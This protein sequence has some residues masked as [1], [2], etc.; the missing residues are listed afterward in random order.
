MRCA[1]FSDTHSNWEALSTFLDYCHKNH[2]DRYWMLGDVV[3]YGADPQIVQKKV[4]EISDV[5]IRGNHDQAMVD[6]ELLAWFNDEAKEAILW[7][8]G[9]FDSKTKEKLAS[10]PYSYVEGGVTLVHASPLNFDQFPYLITW[11]EAAEAFRYFNTPL[12]FIGHTHFPQIFLLKQKASSYLDEGIYPLDRNDRYIISCGSVGQP[13]DN[14]H[15]LAFGIFDDEAYTLEL[16]RLE[17]PKEIAAS[18]IRK[19]GLPRFFA[20]RLL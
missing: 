15:R 6:D 16:V 5:V 10:L 3:G 17:Y 20:D 7:T 13:R 12:C 4:F 1:I 9:Q 14:D 18:K 19:A 11:K 8:R 2:I